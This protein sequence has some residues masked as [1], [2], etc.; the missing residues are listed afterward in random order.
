M[1]EQAIIPIFIPH[2]GCPHDC[3][4]CNQKRITARDSAPTGA[5]ITDL[6]ERNLSTMQELKV[7]EIAFFGGS[8]TAIPIEEQISYLRIA[9]KYKATGSVDR[10]RLST[11]PDCIDSAIL[12]IL[13]E[14]SVDLIE[15]GVQSFDDE[16]LQKSNRGHDSKSVYR[17]A[18][19]I[20]QR[21]FELGVQLMIGLPGDT[22]AK[23]LFSSAE[24]IRLRPS[25]VR[26]YPTI[27]LE[28]TELYEL[29]N[30]GRYQPFSENLMLKTTKAMYRKIS[31]AGI[32][33]IRV[34]LKSTDLITSSCTSYHPAFREIVEGE[35]IRD[36]IESII[37]KQL[38]QEIH[39]TSHPTNLSRLVGHSGS[40]RNYFN[41]KYPTINFYYRGSTTM[42]ISKYLVE[43]VSSSGSVLA[44]ESCRPY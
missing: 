35:I 40:N 14:H 18:D 44:Q 41:K 33:I 20:R 9:N 38:S 22:Y 31:L 28:D 6:I 7:R 36:A 4:F 30:S 23:A 39:I 21:G 24:C 12:D 15:L 10:I 34:G 19:M 5:E 27:I 2:E 1:K 8:F 16:V 11:R 26:L 29:Y 32:K 3:I 25:T 43:F 37:S 13:K 42:S 17:A